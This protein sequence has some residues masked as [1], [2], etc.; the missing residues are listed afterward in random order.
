M[1]YFGF[2]QAL[3][4]G[5]PTEVPLEDSFWGG[6]RAASGS[7]SAPC[8]LRSHQALRIRGRAL[9]THKVAH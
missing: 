8:S 4:V 6:Y 9:L 1:A 7:L 2:V 5:L 3:G